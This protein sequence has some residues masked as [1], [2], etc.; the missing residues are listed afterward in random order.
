MKKS[1]VTQAN[2]YMQSITTSID[3]LD[4]SEVQ[5]CYDN[6][7]AAVYQYETVAKRI[8]EL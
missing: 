3:D 6:L 4:I 8:A 5:R 7:L 1:C 2:T